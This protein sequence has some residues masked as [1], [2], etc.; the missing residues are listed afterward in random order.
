MEVIGTINTLKL[1]AAITEAGYTQATLAQKLNISPNTL[2]FKICGKAKFDIDEATR[3][4][5]LLGIVD[6][7]KKAEIFLQ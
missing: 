3:I 7:R 6:S 5:E 2:S 4:C 1:K